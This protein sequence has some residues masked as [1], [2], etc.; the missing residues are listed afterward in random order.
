MFSYFNPYKIITMTSDDAISGQLQRIYQS[1]AIPIAEVPPGIG[2]LLPR[3]QLFRNAR[4]QT[5]AVV[6]N[7]GILLNS[8]CGRSIDSKDFVIRCNFAE[9]RGF[10][11]DV[12][13][14]TDLVTFNPSILNRKF[15]KLDSNEMRTMFLKRLKSYGKYVLWIPIFSP[16]VMPINIRTA[17]T[18]YERNLENLKDV[19]LAFPGNILPEILE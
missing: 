14:A 3:K 19:Q 18:F 8:S 11:R 12:G 13:I 10:E 1:K 7:G 16:H 6:G 15:G 2:R 4:Y 5:C 17:L 9:M